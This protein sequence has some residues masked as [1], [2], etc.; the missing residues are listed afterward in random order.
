ML[1][2][3]EAADDEDARTRL[4][5]LLVDHASPLIRQIVRRQLLSGGGAAARTREQDAE[6]LHGA[7]MLR[8]TAQLWEL[9]REEREHATAA[10]SGAAPIASFANYVARAAFN[11]CHEWLRQRAPRRARLQSRV[12]YVLTHDPRLMMREAADR[13]WWCGARFRSSPNQRGTRPDVPSPTC[14]EAADEQP[15]AVRRETGDP[16]V[17]PRAFAAF[18]H[19]TLAALDGRAGSPRWSPRLAECLGEEDVPPAARWRSAREAGGGHDGRED[20][21]AV[22]GRCGCGISGRRSWTC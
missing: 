13:D 7:L 9:R 3:L 6:D 15:A 11:A 1:P 17:S 18:V 21:A 22:R 8:L 19:A 4:G 14:G 5:D 2:S 20:G 12:R 16:A 10:A